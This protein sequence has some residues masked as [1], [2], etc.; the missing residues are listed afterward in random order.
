MFGGKKGKSTQSVQ[1]A[2]TALNRAPA[3]LDAAY[4][5]LEPLPNP[6][7]DTVGRHM[8]AGEIA[9]GDSAH[10]QEIDSNN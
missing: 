1:T 3:R 5:N 8:M 7:L 2:Q 4:Q 10:D 6:T 9:L